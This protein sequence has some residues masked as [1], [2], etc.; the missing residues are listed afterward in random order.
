MTDEANLPVPAEVPNINM[1]AALARE[2]AYNLRPL[3]AVLKMFNLTQEQYDLYSK[4]P[5]FV[6]T[7]EAAV[8][9][10]ESASST[11]RRI[12]L[13]SLAAIEDAL[14]TLAAR[15]SNTD[16]ALP[17]AVE[18][19]KLISKWAGLGEQARE[20]SPGEKFS[21]VINLGDDKTL[22]FEKDVT[23]TP[24]LIEQKETADEPS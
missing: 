9:D 15:M 20:G 17:G 12:K 23:P 2:L 6:R 10:W 1:L 7:L 19:G 21:I 11:E 4:L 13:Q 8:L 14:P 5:F 22:T 3:P 24:P 18:A 16:E